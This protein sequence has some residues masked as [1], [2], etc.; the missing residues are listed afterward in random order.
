[1]FQYKLEVVVSI[2]LGYEYRTLFEKTS[3]LTMKPPP[4]LILELWSVLEML[5]LTFAPTAVVEPMIA[6]MLTK[7]KN[8]IVMNVL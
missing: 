8:C 1:M 7:R 5:R 2:A 4:S 3:Y 6:A